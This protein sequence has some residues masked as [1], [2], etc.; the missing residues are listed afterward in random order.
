MPFFAFRLAYIF[1][2]V[3]QMPWALYILEFL[4]FLIFS[5]CWPGFPVCMNVSEYWIFAFGLPCVPFPSEDS[6]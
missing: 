3:A 1:L 2:S 6:A 5:S 4:D